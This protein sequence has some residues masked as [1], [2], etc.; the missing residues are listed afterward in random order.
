MKESI[1]LQLADIVKKDVEHFATDFNIDLDTLSKY[2][3]LE[4]IHITRRTGT[5]LIMFYGRKFYPKTESERVKYLFGT[6]NLKE[7]IKSDHITRD[8]YLNYSPLTITYFNGKTLKKIDKATAEN[9]HKRHLQ[10]VI[11]RI[12]EEKRQLTNQ[13]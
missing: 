2:P 13:S 4:F 5:A 12:E 10:S 8:H 7:L 11:N 1:K 9:L 6:A 3:G